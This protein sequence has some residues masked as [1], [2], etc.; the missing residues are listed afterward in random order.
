MEQEKEPELLFSFLKLY[1][2][3]NYQD[4]INNSPYCLQYNLY[5]VSLEN[6]ALD[7]PIIPLLI[8]LVYPITCL[9]D[10]ILIV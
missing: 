9:L 5:D 7:Q 3:F 10:I 1:W 8:F 6:L 2:P 4:F